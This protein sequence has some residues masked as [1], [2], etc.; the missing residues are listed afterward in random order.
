MV[1][2]TASAAAIFTAEIRNSIIRFPREKVYALN[3]SQPMIESSRPLRT[4][5]QE[6]EKK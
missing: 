4:S 6:K 5:T 1:S 3:G 2:V